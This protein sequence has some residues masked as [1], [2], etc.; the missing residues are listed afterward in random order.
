VEEAGRRGIPLMD[1]LD[2]M[3]ESSAHD[4]ESETEAKPVDDA[5]VSNLFA[6]AG[7]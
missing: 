2:L 4:P 1:A 5:T 6:A 7:R 3:K